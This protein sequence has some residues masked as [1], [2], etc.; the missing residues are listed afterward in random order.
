M[1]GFST[2][3]IFGADT[4]SNIESNY[5]R[6]IISKYKGAYGMGLQGPDFF[7]YYL[8][9]YAMH[10]TNLG[11]YMHQNKTALFLSN[12]MKARNS[13]L[14]ER[15]RQIAEAYI[16]GFL[17]HYLLD[18][19][20]HPYIYGRTDYTS[21]SPEYTAK[22]LALETAIDKEMLWKYK[23]YKPSR[24]P[25][26]KT[27]ALD[28]CT[29]RVISSLLNEAL[30]FTYPDFTCTYTM[31]KCAL[32]SMRLGTASLA[33]K[34]GKKKPV[35]YSIEKRFLGY[36]LVSNLIPSDSINTVDDCLN[37]K[38]EPWSHPWKDNYSS[39]ASFIELFAEAQKEYLTIIDLA[40]KLFQ[41][42]SGSYVWNRYKKLFRLLGDKNYHSGLPTTVSPETI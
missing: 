38:K 31:I 24:F 11:S 10:G 22:H 39:D 12:L 14:E 29:W 34:K 15:D 13:F 40:S 18:T 17:G 35:A 8:P 3:Y 25:Q 42:K 20:C 41:E 19:H 28:P 7:L 27:I 37:L 5:A 33:D 32:I 4:Y 16:F 9:S 26:S 21:P 2:H 23:H 30:F 36:S 6:H 1:P